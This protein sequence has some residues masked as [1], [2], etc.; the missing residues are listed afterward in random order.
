[1]SLEKLGAVYYTAADAR[2]ALGLTEDSFQYWVKTKRVNKIMLPGRKQGV[3]SRREIDKLAR[4]IEAAMLIHIEET[5]EYR[6]ATLEDLEE[7]YQLSHL[8]FGKAAHTIEI[9][10][11]FMEKNPHIDYHL[12]HSDKLVA[13]INIIPFNHETILRF[14]QGKERGNEIDPSNVEQFVP[15]RPIECILMEMATTPTVPPSNRTFYGSRLLEGFSNTLEEWGKRGINLTKFYATSSTPTG[16]HILKNAMFQVIDDLGDGRLAFELD[17][18]QSS[19]KLL[20]GYQEA[21]KQWNR[22]Q[23]TTSRAKIR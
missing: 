6:E 5:Y 3:Y 15:G 19:S 16:I 18:T 2:K 22:Q 14:I 12:Y 4:R 10:R 20:A 21:F 8:I 13:F 17:I 11:A 1:M 7:E 23:D 9:R